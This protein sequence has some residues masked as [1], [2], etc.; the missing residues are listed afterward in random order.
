[1]EKIPR[2][3]AFI[4]GIPIMFHPPSLFFS[5]APYRIPARYSSSERIRDLKD[6][7]AVGDFQAGKRREEE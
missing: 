6:K 7:R 5:E 3:I 2:S 4:S 1:M